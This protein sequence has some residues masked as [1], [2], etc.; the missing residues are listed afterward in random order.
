M[1]ILW[2]LRERWDLRSISRGQRQQ[3]ATEGFGAGSSN[4]KLA[5]GGWSNCN[6]ESVPKQEKTRE[7]VLGKVKE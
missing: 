7:V 4:M 5:L 6:I 1:K 2:K 3:G